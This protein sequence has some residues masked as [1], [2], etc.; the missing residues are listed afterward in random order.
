MNGLGLTQPWLEKSGPVNVS[1]ALGEHVDVMKSPHT[2][3][4]M[5]NWVCQLDE[6]VDSLAVRRR[7]IIRIW[8]IVQNQGSRLVDIGFI[9]VAINIQA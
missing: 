5:I 6:E 9:V 7:F 1:Q 2:A 4:A 3:A 8:K